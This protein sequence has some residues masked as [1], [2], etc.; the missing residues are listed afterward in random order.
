MCVKLVIYQK[1]RPLP[2]LFQIMMI[3]LNHGE[4]RSF[5]SSTFNRTRSMFDV[6]VKFWNQPERHK[7]GIAYRH[8]PQSYSL[9]LPYH[10]ARSSQHSKHCGLL[11]SVFS[12][13]MSS[14]R[15]S[16]N[17]RY[18]PA[19]G[20][21]IKVTRHVSRVGCRVVSTRV[22]KTV[23]SDYSFPSVFRV[24][25]GSRWTEF[26]DI[27]YLSIFRKTCPENSSFLKTGQIL[28]VPHTKTNI[29]FWPHHDQL[30]L[31]WKTF[32]TKVVQKI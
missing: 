32:H 30:I 2:V 20:D 12:E 13:Q 24:Q 29:Y 25:L 16:S 5:I 27:W 8:A 7:P 15:H 6:T 19:C 21:V 9:S 26:H 18:Q 22:S 10:A 4:H 11:S 23:K 14:I 17:T 3:I 28:Q 31:Q 1:E